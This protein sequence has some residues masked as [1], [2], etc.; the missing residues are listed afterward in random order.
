MAQ[1]RHHWLTL[2]A[3]LALLGSAAAPALAR[4]YVPQGRC[5]PHERVQ[6]DTVPA[7]HCVALVADETQGLAAPRRILEVTPGRFWVID[8]GANWVPKRGR[9]LELTLPPGAA[10]AKVSTLAEGLDRPLGLAKGPDGQIWMGEVH[11]V[12]RTPLP[13]PGQP[14]RR[15]VMLPNLPTSGAHPLKE[16]AF[17]PGDALYVNMGSVTDSCRND[18]QQQPVPCPELGGTQPRA[19]VYRAQLD[20]AQGWKVTRF[21]PFATG[22]RNSVALTVLPSGAVLQGE[23]SIDYPDAAQP[24]EKLNRLQAGRHYGWPY[25]VGKGMAARGYEKRY[26]CAQATPPAQTWPAH[27]APL[28]LLQGTAGSPFAGQLLVAWHGHRPAGQR[29]MR[30]PIRADGT[31]TGPPR[32]VLEGWA[33]RQGVRPVGHPTGLAIDHDGRLWVVEDIHRAVLLVRPI[34]AP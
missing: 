11:Q 18:A 3:A 32:P 8:M 20:P 34:Q 28:H 30:V 21:E 6:I 5:G 23:N 14:I 10:R 19:A 24:P 29:V 33:A 13:P 25:C 7:G 17:G 16:I 2:A 1:R 26:D 22:L 15:E 27:A 31:P 12:W 4:G 9:L